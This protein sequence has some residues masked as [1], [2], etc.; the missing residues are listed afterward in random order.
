MTNKQRILIVDDDE[1]I[2]M[3]LGE[4]LTM[5][6]HE[7][8]TASDGLEALAKVKLDI[9]LVLMDVN[10]PNMDGYEVIKRIRSEPE[11]R[12]LPIIMVTAMTSREDRLRAVRAGA[13]DFIAKPIDQTELEVRTMSLLRMKDIQ[14]TIKRHKS[15]LEDKVQQRTAVLRKSLDEMVDAQRKTYDAYLDT[16]RRL[17]IAAE[18]RDEGTAAHIMRMS[19]YAAVLARGLNFSSG[20]IEIILQASPMHDI[21]KIGIPDGIL[22][23]KGTLEDKEWE[24]MRQHTIIGSR[25]LKESNSDFLKAGE[26]IAATHHEK[27]D[28]SGYPNGLKGEEIPHLGRICAVADVFDALTT[29]RPYKEAFSNEEAFDII[30]KGRETHFDPEVVDIFFDKV[31][32]IETIQSK[33]LEGSVEMKTLDFDRLR[34]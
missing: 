31:S 2:R 20:Q 33:Y 16:I 23:K 25:I 34:Y 9:D 22:L 15:E 10:M 28:G 30:R 4:Y 14:D 17:A 32:E 26:L 27:W 19:N 3:I 24:I 1:G 6:G 8:E 12:D 21:G 11:H 13:N 5:Q 7:Y 29:K 18:Y